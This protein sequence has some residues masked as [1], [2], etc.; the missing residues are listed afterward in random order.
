MPEGS[1]AEAGEYRERLDERHGRA[2]QPEVIEQLIH[3]RWMQQLGAR[4]PALAYDAPGSR[5]RTR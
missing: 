2:L 4:E 5:D 1:A 3:L